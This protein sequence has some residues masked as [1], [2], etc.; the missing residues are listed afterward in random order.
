MQRP[1]LT[2]DE[3]FELIDWRELR[4]EI[5]QFISLRTITTKLSYLE[6]MLINKYEWRLLGSSISMSMR[7]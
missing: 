1:A 5:L 2:L 6:R 3:G 4:K 7:L